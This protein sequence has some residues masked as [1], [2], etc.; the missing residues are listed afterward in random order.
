[1]VTNLRRAM[2][3]TAKKAEVTA[4]KLL[5]TVVSI[6]VLCATV[7]TRAYTSPLSVVPG[8]WSFAARKDEFTMVV[9]PAWWPTLGPPTERYT[10]EVQ[11]SR[12]RYAIPC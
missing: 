5:A 9:F 1:M 3:P 2:R 10:F 4:L 12:H 8:F 7:P 6:L 11:K